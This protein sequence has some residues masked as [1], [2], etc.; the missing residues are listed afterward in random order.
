MLIQVTG[1]ST[2]SS[3][4]PSNIFYITTNKLQT[5]EILLKILDMTRNVFR[6][7]LIFFSSR[8]HFY[9]IFI[10]SILSSQTT[11]SH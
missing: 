3:Y 11:Q 10:I 8:S 7:F 9:F 6:L 4:S 1:N 2:A 5:I